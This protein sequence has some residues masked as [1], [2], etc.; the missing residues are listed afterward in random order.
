MS[1]AP[2]LPARCPS[3]RAEAGATVIGVVQDDGRVAHFATSL[4]ADDDFLAVA[5]SQGLPEQ[6][7][8]FSSSCAEHKCEQWTG[9]QCG[10]ID[11]IA[12]RL[13]DARMPAIKD[14]TPPCTIRSDCRWFLQRGYEA[15][16]I[17]TLVVT[18]PGSDSAKGT[19]PRAD[20]PLGPDRDEARPGRFVEWTQP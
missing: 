1:D 7:F 5:R 14:R 15:C 3:A 16:G 13:A 19:Q 4:V 11:G 2:A 20:E 9:R 18:D 12:R 8:R 10:L 17:C 6:H